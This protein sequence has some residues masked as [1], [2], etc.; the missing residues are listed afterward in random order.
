METAINSRIYEL[1]NG[2]YYQHICIIM[3]IGQRLSIRMQLQ[4]THCNVRN[5]VLWIM[6]PNQNHINSIIINLI[7]IIV[8]VPMTFYG[9]FTWNKCMS[10]TIASPVE[11]HLSSYS[12][13]PFNR[14][15]SAYRVD[16]WLGIHKYTNTH[17]LLIKI[18]TNREMIS[19]IESNNIANN[20]SSNFL[21]HL[22]LSSNFIHKTR[23][24]SRHYWPNNKSHF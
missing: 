18:G 3:L 1:A 4:I 23:F 8:S 20:L 19:I 10:M 13:W 24:P 2:V 6:M 17:R 7:I 11:I 5:N 14:G 12:A 16:Y 21:V 15:L 22:S 9:Y